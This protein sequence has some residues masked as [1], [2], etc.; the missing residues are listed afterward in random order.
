MNDAP[1]IVCVRDHTHAEWL[2]R[3]AKRLAE[4]KNLPILLLSVCAQNASPAEK[5]EFVRV[6]D[7]EAR[8]AG[9]ELML[10]FSDRPVTAAA[11]FIRE[12]SAAGVVVGVPLEENQG[13]VRG[14]RHCLPHIPITVAAGYHIVYYAN[15][16]CVTGA[17]CPVVG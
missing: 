5:N 7:Q 10:L 4:P 6:M 15:P 12:R 8:N 17:R 16:V 1:I 11:A 2:L 13:F 14:L 9:A 3:S